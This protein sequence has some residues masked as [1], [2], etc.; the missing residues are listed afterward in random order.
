M[1]K[2]EVANSN[3]FPHVKGH[4]LQYIANKAGCDQ[5]YVWMISQGEREAKS[6][7]AKA[8]KNALEK[9]NKSIENALKKADNALV[10]IE[11]ND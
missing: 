4:L 10:V 9:L 3:Q 6:V 1:K 5:S 2:T 7:K 11:D 8:I